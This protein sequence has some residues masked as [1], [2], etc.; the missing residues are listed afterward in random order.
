MGDSRSA[1]VFADLFRYAG[2]RDD[3]DLIRKLY[4]VQ[5]D[6]GLDFAL[7]ECGVDEILARADLVRVRWV[8]AYQEWETVYPYHPE[9]F[10]NARAWAPDWEEWDAP[11]DGSP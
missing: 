8:A 5:E 10:T 4:E 11:K 2:E 6:H 3:V 9:E 1:E 7:D